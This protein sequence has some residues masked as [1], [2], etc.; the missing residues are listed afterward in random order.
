MTLGASNI[1][2]GLPDRELLNNA[3][4]AM[5]I[6]SGLTCLITDAAKVRAAV[7]AADLVLGRD[8]HARRYIGAYRQRQEQQK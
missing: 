5:A 3:F 8:K 6:A 1:S 2:F 7:V 4:V